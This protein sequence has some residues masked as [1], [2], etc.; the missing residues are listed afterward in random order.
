MR[1]LLLVV[2]FG[3]FVI[4]AIAIQRLFSREHGVDRRMKALQAGGS[5][6]ALVH[7]L[8]LWKAPEMPMMRS[9]AAVLV[10][11]AALGV[12][13]AAR[14]GM[15]GH[16]LTLAFSPDNPTILLNTG[17]YTLTWTAGFAAVPS[18]WTMVSTA[19]MFIG[20]WRAA[21]M[22]ESKFMASPFAAAYVEYRKQAGMFLPYLR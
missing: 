6:S 19:T 7:L 10:Y 16:Q 9:L 15:I 22:E 12:F 3:S 18:P 5:V 8:C 4:Y 2:A 11:L 20:Y 21:K 1:W 13:F 14:K 17:T